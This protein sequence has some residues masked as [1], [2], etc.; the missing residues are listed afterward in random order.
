[1]PEQ[2][3]IT[4]DYGPGAPPLFKQLQ[5][6]NVKG[7]NTANISHYQIDVNSVHRLMR[8]EYITPDQATEMLIKINDR[9]FMPNNDLTNKK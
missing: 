9:I 5:K 4:I 8:R 6:N 2:K 7:F 3:E 1:M